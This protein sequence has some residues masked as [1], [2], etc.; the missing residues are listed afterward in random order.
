MA[1]ALIAPAPADLAA[2]AAACEPFNTDARP[3]ADRI[4]GAL[5]V[6]MTASGRRVALAAVEIDGPAAW[7]VAC[8]SSGAGVSV[9]DVMPEFL[10]LL[11]VREVRFLTRRLSLIRR[12]ASRGAQ[13][14]GYLM[15]FKG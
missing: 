12:A 15:T 11:R 5:V 8:T 13:L 9:C 6:E 4:A 1:L 7:V 3:L 2:L 14:G 10:Q